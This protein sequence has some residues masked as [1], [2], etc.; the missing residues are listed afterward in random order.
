MLAEITVQ[1][2]VLA[3]AQEFSHHF[4]GQFLRIR[5]GRRGPALAQGFSREK[6]LQRVMHEAKDCY[7]KYVQVYHTPPREVAISSKGVRAWIFN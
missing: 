4:H 1:G 6:G 3:E 5:Q 7:D 2:G